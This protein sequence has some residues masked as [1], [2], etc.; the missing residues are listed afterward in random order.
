MDPAKEPYRDVGW[1]CGAWEREGGVGR[2]E[3][4]VGGR[5]VG[6]SRFQAATAVGPALRRPAP[7]APWP[8]G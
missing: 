6:A 5:V 8:D 1:T 7:L 2:C 3:C 4:V